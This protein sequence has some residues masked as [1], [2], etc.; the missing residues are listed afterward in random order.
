MFTYT[1]YMYRIFLLLAEYCSNMK[2]FGMMRA[3]LS[4]KP[5]FHTDK[6]LIFAYFTVV[7]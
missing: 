2:V 5:K 4:Y 6:Y 1:P 7:V 3:C